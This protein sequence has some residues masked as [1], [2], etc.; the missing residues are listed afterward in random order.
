MKKLPI[1]LFM[2]IL[3]SWS[4]YARQADVVS[5]DKRLRFRISCGDSL[6]YRVE[7]KGKPLI[8]RSCIGLDISQLPQGAPVVLSLS[9]IHI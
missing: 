4:A 2:L 3:C 1:L 8:G 6:E 7:Y 9:L 5:P